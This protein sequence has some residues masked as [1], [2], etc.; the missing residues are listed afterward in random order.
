MGKMS[1]LGHPWVWP[2]RLR[3]AETASNLSSLSA[4]SPPAAAAAASASG[5]RSLLLQ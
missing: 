4:L 3:S 1:E 5:E 2:W